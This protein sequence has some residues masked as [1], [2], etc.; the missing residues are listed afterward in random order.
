MIIDAKNMVL[1]R[2]ATIAAK[3]ALMGEKVDIINCE[4]AVI[5]GNKQ[6]VF[7]KYNRKSS[8]GSP[9]KGPF[10][11]RRSDMFVR[12]VIRGMLPYKQEKGRQAFKNIMCYMGVPKE[13]EGKKAE[14]IKGADFSKIQVLRY[15]TVG[16]VC[17]RL[18]NK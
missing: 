2:I 17:M 3:K 7:E 13:F 16:K 14:Q 9:A 6:N 8:M 4:N 12:R 11:A 15:T 10:L 1:G 5:T 18:R